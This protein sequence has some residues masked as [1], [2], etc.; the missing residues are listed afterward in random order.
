M[1]TG[2][3]TRYNSYSNDIVSLVNLCRRIYLVVELYW[4]TA[5]Y[6]YAA[7]ARKNAIPEQPSTG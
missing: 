6:K 7:T 2:R 4:R 3:R 5:L 1:Y